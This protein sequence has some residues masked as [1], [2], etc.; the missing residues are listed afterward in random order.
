[1]RSIDVRTIAV[2]S[3]REEEWE[4]V[5]TNLAVSEKTVDE[6]RGLQ[7]KLPEIKNNL[8]AFFLSA[9]P[10]DYTV[11]EGFCQGD[12][13]QTRLTVMGTSVAYGSRHI[14]TGIFDPLKLKVISSRRRLGGVLKQTL[15]AT[16]SNTEPRRE[17]LWGVVQKQTILAKQLGYENAED[18][19]KD[20]L[21][22]ENVRHDIDFELTIS[23]LA[24]INSVTFNKST[25]AVEIS[26]ISG[27]RNLQLNIVQS[28]A[29]NGGSYYPIW[30]KNLPIGETGKLLV[31][32]CYVAEEDI[33]PPDLLPFDYL[34]LE[35][36]YR[37]AGLTLDAFWGKVPLQNVVEPLFKALDAFCPIDKFKEMLL[38][39]KD[40][41]N[42]PEKIFENAV[43]WLLSLVGFHTIYLDANSKATKTS[44][45]VLRKFDK[46]EIGSADILAYEDNERLLLVDCDIGGLDE[47]KI[48][49]LIGAREH[50]ENLS[51]CQ[52]LKIIPVLFSPKTL[53]ETAKNKPVA[54]ADRVVIE[55]MLEELSKGDRKSARSK[56]CLN[57]S[58]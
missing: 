20:I 23:D 25:F 55:S 40:F 37:S 58:W 6:V 14:K 3:P 31:E 48:Q 56:I 8:M 33:Q 9:L 1:L 39:P 21:R 51:N 53:G 43:S 15:T 57:S 42:A 47:Q 44:F 38:N 29:K 27:L 16:N 26:G 32:K 34:S 28:R 46:C 41:E 54:I 19:I 18:L 7:E 35:L 50:I 11:F 24:K 10:F 17:E 12:I 5:V 49:K 45:D 2:R 52:E 36:I 4:N 22:I 30:R 13:G